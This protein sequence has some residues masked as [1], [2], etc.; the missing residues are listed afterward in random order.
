M[1]N[2]CNVVN[3]H[4]KQINDIKNDI[5]NELPTKINEFLSDMC[6]VII[7]SNTEGPNTS[8][9]LGCNAKGSNESV[10]VGNF[11]T[12]GGNSK[13]VVAGFMANAP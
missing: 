12:S 6:P 5:K 8:V 4:T 7:G 2:V 11:A 13:N 9:V 1:S 3:C 10:V